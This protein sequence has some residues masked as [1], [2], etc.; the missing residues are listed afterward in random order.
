TTSINMKS[1]PLGI[2]TVACLLPWILPTAAQFLDPNCGIGGGRPTVVARIINGSR[3]DVLSSPWMAYLHSAAGHFRCAGSL[4]TT[5]PYNQPQNQLKLDNFRVVRL[6]AYKRNTKAYVY[7]DREYYPETHKVSLGVRHRLYD[8]ASHINDIALLRL[9]SYVEY[10][11][12]IRP[13]CIVLDESWRQHIDSIHWLTG[14]GWGKTEAAQ[15]SDVLL[16]L[17]I[18]RQPPEVCQD[19]LAVDYLMSNQFCVGNMDSN[20]CN[21]DSG[22]P[23]GALVNYDTYR[24]V[25]VGIA[26]YTNS[27][28]AGASVLTDVLSHA[29]WIVNV[30]RYIEA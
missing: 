6:G 4:I 18:Q 20:L 24:F 26:S 17:P 3:A 30:I 1:V 5:R 12:N 29:Q 25:Q 22:G 21:G 27:M 2:A 15:A 11:E 13:I 23:V 7:G 14:T 9:E 19:F 28:C 8:P 10:K 16:T